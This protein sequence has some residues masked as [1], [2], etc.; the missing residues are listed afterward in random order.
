MLVPDQDGAPPQ[1]QLAVL[2][3]DDEAA[4]RPPNAFILFCRSLKPSL[5]DDPE[6]TELDANRLLGKMWQVTDEQTHI[7]YREQAIQLADLYRSLHPDYDD[8]RR[9]KQPPHQNIKVADPIRIKVILDA[10]EF[11]QAVAD[12]PM[13]LLKII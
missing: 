5:M 3:A 2:T 13:A 4:K 1:V 9:K 8:L 12:D 7:Y 10:T 11:D 6:I